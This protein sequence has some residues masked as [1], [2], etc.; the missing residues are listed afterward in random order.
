MAMSANNLD[1]GSHVFELAA[2]FNKGGFALMPSRAE[3]TYELADGGE[4]AAVQNTCGRTIRLS[5]CWLKLDAAPLRQ[6]DDA[7]P[8]STASC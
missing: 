5:A 6:A 2:G 8:A 4:S 7:C 3:R 1:Q